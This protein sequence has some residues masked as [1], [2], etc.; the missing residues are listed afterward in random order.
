[1]SEAREGEESGEE[2]VWTAIKHTTNR[3]CKPADAPA[4]V[5]GL[6]AATVKSE[7]HE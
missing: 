6:D 1:M 4:V 7:Q 3:K 2:Y 5:F